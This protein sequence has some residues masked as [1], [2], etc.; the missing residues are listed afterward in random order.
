MPQDL[1][2]STDQS[3]TKSAEVTGADFGRRPWFSD[4]QRRDA[5]TQAEPPANGRNPRVI[6]GVTVRKFFTDEQ[7]AAAAD[8]ESATRSATPIN[9]DTQH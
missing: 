4:A 8:N 5:A 1:T 3:A 9:N 2:P 6:E 7:R